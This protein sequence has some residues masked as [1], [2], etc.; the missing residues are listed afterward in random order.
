MFYD[1]TIYSLLSI[2]HT[3]MATQVSHP[4]HCL[5]SPTNSEMYH[6]ATAF[7][8]QVQCTICWL[9]SLLKCPPLTLCGNTLMPS[10]LTNLVL[11]L[12]QS[13]ILLVQF[14]GRDPL[15]VAPPN[16][17]PLEAVIPVPALHQLCKCLHCTCIF[18]L[19]LLLSVC[20]YWDQ[21]C[22][23]CPLAHATANIQHALYP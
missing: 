2:K 17:V 12:A 7:I 22:H 14:W 23:T 8:S 4:C 11:M 1:P 13:C 5:S 16:D 21:N 19:Y 18:S 9:V 20:T 6:V 10:P 3:V 15:L